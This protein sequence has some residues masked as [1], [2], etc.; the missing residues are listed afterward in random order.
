MLIYYELSIYGKFPLPKLWISIHNFGANANSRG[1]AVFCT[2]LYHGKHTRFERCDIQGEVKPEHL[3]AWVAERLAAVQT[4][5]AEKSKIK[6]DK[7]AR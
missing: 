6:P 4:E 2:N 5:H 3:P 1:N 7:G